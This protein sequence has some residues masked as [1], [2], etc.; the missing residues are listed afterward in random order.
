MKGDELA[1]QVS[2]HPQDGEGGRGM[3]FTQ[4]HVSGP[5]KLR[6]QAAWAPFMPKLLTKLTAHGTR[7]VPVTGG[8]GGTGDAELTGS[9]LRGPRYSFTRSNLP[10]SLACW[11]Q[12]TKPQ[13]ESPL[14]VKMK[15]RTGP[16][17]SAQFTGDC[18]SAGK[19]APAPTGCVHRWEGHTG[20]SGRGRPCQEE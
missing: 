2:G 14:K 1:P 18:Q 9:G 10:C 5:G 12:A 4:G 15:I 17:F 19:T 7:W 11:N 13:Q 20:A 3:Q 16:C 6:F 8:S